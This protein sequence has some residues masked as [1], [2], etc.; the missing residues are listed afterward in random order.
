MVAVLFI[1]INSSN[2]SSRSSNSSSNSNNSSNSSSS[3]SNSVGSFLMVMASSL[4]EL[5]CFIS[6]CI[7]RDVAARNVLVTEDT[8]LKIADF[9][10]A[11]NVHELDYYRK[12][13]DV[14]IYT[15]YRIIETTSLTN[16]KSA[17]L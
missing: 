7:H 13:G 17:L 11:R 6:Q 3:S 9:G 4:T 10:L 2:S 14:S 12:M 1:I 15:N 16:K 5:M 8:T